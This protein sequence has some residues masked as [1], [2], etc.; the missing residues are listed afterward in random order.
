MAKKI[1]EK[2]EGLTERQKNIARLRAKLN[3]ADPDDI[4]VFTK[5]KIM[6]YI[7]NI[8]FPPYSLYRIWKNRSPFNTNEKIIQTSV[9]SIYMVVLAST[10]ING[11]F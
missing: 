11:G 2:E 1:K 3:E 6:T 7:F 4:K 8:I 10:L 5:Y 9:C